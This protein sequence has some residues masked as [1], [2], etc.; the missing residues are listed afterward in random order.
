MRDAN[1][2]APVASWVA[3]AASSRVQEQS[4]APPELPRIHELVNAGINR[5][6]YDSGAWQVEV[7]GDGSHLD[8][9]VLTSA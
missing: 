7:W 4:I 3:K 6:R 8:A 2:A 5:L 9:S 1:D